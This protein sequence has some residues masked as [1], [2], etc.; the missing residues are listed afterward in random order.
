MVAGSQALSGVALI[1][2]IFSDVAPHIFKGGSSDSLRVI[3]INRLSQQMLYA[4]K[5][6]PPGFLVRG[7]LCLATLHL[8]PLYT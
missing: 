3:C 8:G 7:A 2:L 1:G 4:S 6:W 5:R